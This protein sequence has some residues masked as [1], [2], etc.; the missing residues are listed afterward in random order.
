MSSSRYYFFE[1]LDSGKIIPL[2]TEFNGRVN[3]GNGPSPRRDDG[4]YDHS[5]RT[6]INTATYA[7]TYVI[8]GERR[9]TAAD[10]PGKAVRVKAWYPKGGRDDPTEFFD[11]RDES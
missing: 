11:L 7:D 1:R 2:D 4:S 6:S 9:L 5:A 8:K 10:F 3:V